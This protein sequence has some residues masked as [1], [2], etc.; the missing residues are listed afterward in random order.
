MRNFF[1]SSG[2]RNSDYPAGGYAPPAYPPAY[3]YPSYPG[4]QAPYPGYGYPAQPQVPPTYPTANVAPSMPAQVAPGAQP[5]PQPPAYGTAPSEAS[6]YQPM[7]AN[8][9]PATHYRFRPL[10]ET[11]SPPAQESQ[12]QRLPVPNATPQPPQVAP[13]TAGYRKPEPL[14]PPAYPE[15]NSYPE[16]LAPLTYPEAETATPAPKVEMRDT[17]IQQDPNLRF[18]PLDQPGYSSELGE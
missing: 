6:G 4:Y 1:G 15:A 2:R 3:G 8:P 7:F 10:E 14:A 13:P 17:G 11:S 5:M 16:P 9:D 18:R 12:Q